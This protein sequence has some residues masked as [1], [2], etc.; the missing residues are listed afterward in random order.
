MNTFKSF[1]VYSNI[2][3]T[4]SHVLADA[5]LNESYILQR[6]DSICSKPYK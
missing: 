5:K 6:K 2:M 1:Q 3:L 4:H